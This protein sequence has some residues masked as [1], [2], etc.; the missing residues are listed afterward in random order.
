MKIFSFINEV[1]FFDLLD[2]AVMALLI[3]S[4][5]GWFKKT[6]AASVLIGILMIACFYLIARQFNLVLTASVFRAFFAV[7]LVA[8][9]VIFQEELRH[10]FEQVAVLGLRRHLEKDKA[11]RLA[12]TEVLALV[13]TLTDMAREKIGV[14]IVLRGKEMI[15]RHLEGGEELQGILS[16]AILKSL[17]DPHTPGHDGALVIEG[18]LVTQFSCHLPLSKNFKLLGTKGTRHAAALGLSELADALCL[19]V[20]E[21]KG[22][23]SVARHGELHEISDPEKLNILLEKF[24]R[25]INPYVEPKTWRNFFKTNLVEKG[26]ALSIASVL[27]FLQVYGSKVVYKTYTI[28]VEYAEVPRGFAITAIDPEEVDVTFSAPRRS[29]YF[30]PNEKLH[31]LLKPWKAKEGDRTVRISPTY[32]TVPKNFAVENIDPNRVH[33]R[34]EKK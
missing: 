2:I 27:W 6:R 20:S 19:V 3:Y 5:L 1:G 17:F 9:V 15:L 26:I 14:L 29:F 31:I 25:E 11:T 18:N 4:V 7:I 28:P 23:I 12:H 8:M 33:L 21:E 32:I 16:E 30:L 24:Y 22:T 10:F 13:R 34:I